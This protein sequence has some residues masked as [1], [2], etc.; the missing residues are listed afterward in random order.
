[1]DIFENEYL[2]IRSR[3]Q[4]L[5]KVFGNY[6]FILETVIDFT[7]RQIS[8]GGCTPQ[9]HDI[10]RDEAAVHQMHNGFIG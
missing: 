1:L 9:F 4:E 6:V 2:A 7:F 8:R 5:K 3:E 10:G